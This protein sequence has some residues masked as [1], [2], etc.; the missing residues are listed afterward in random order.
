MSS[1]TKE[2][3]NSGEFIFFEGDIEAH[4][5]IIESGTVSIFTKNQS[6]QKMILATLQPGDTFGEFALIES[7]ARTASAMAE[8]NVKLMKISQEGY[9]IML[10]DL[11]LWA[12]S[13]LKSFITRLKTMNTQLKIKK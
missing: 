4:F 1:I 2:T 13:M 10:N 6:G 5:Y 11:P 8:T 7:G 9:D 3:Y 12:S